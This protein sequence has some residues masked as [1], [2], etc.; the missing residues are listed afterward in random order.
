MLSK[1]TQVTYC[2]NNGKI[3]LEEPISLMDGDN[4]GILQLKGTLEDN[5]KAT[6]KV[7]PPEGNV[8]EV[9]ASIVPYKGICR[10]FSLPNKGEGEYKCQVVLTQGTGINK[11]INKSQIF[12]YNVLPSL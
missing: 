10:E 6:L 1:K 8:I 2:I 4:V 7:Q 12:T 11:S 5:I 3:I 9:T